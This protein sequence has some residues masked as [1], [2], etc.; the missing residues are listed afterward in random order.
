[1]HWF[2]QIFRSKKQETPATEVKQDP[3]QTLVRNLKD[4][5]Y[6]F[7]ESIAVALEFFFRAKLGCLAKKEGEKIMINPSYLDAKIDTV[8]PGSIDQEVSGQSR[9]VYFSSKKNIADYCDQF[10]V[11]VFRGPGE[12]WRVVGFHY[13]RDKKGHYYAVFEPHHYW[14]ADRSKSGYLSPDI[15]PD[16]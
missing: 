2:F 1:M 10:R 13:P 9:I 15:N 6:N 16:Y 12:S 11:V 8:V 4:G 14:F 5:H 7:P 3:E